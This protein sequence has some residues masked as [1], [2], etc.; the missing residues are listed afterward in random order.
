MGSSVRRVGSGVTKRSVV[1]AGHKTSISLEDTFW[2]ALKRVA[3][4]R[5][6]TISELLAEIDEERQHDNLSSAIRQFLFDHYLALVPHGDHDS[7]LVNAMP[8]RSPPPAGK[9]PHSS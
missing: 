1:I 2:T 7:A 3:H 9:P 5:R 4:E 8:P 6:L